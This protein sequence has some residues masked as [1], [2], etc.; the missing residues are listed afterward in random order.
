MHALGLSKWITVSMFLRTKV[1]NVG[2][3]RHNY[4]MMEG[5]KEPCRTGLELEVAVWTHNLINI[6]TY[7]LSIEKA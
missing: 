7:I 6:N 2:E 3:G 5:E 1:L 4:G